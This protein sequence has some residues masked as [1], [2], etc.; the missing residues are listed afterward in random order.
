LSA[1]KYIFHA[2]R[3]PLPCLEAHNFPREIQLHE[4]SPPGI[5][6]GG[7]ELTLRGKSYAPWQGGR[8]DGFCFAL[9]N[10][11]VEAVRAAKYYMWSNIVCGRNKMLFS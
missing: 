6:E 5:G 11:C 1:L 7:M 8:W 2:K 9:E 3:D 4:K 10:V